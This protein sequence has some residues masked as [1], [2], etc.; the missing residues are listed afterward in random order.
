MFTDNFVPAHAAY[1]SFVE[2]TS[3][4]TVTNWRF[5]M[6]LTGH[7]CDFSFPILKNVNR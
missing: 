7:Q 2:L 4:Y 1:A 3:D 6:I 5:M